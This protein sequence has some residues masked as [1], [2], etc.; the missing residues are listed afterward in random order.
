MILNQ[1]LLVRLCVQLNFAQ[2]NYI[3]AIESLFSVCIFLVYYNH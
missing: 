1:E 2:C 3:L